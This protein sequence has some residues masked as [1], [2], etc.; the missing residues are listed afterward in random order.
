ML[1]SLHRIIYVSRSLLRGDEDQV[2]VELRRILAV[3]RRNNASEGLTG[4]LLL[5]HGSFAQ[6]L[7]GPMGAVEHAFERIQDDPR[8]ADL[9][10]VEVGAVAARA[11]PDWS[12][13]FAGAAAA[14]VA[15][16]VRA[17]LDQVAA[18]SHATAAESVLGLLDGLIR[19][20]A[21]WAMAH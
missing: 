17:V 20:E 2:A 3:S 7:E 5:G 11:F 15:P 1:T 9:V 14:G 21:E 18:S 6:V 4:A 13:A 12:M 8:H 10:V 16:R 19:R